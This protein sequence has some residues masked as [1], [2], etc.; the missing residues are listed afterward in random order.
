MKRKSRNHATASML[1]RRAAG[2]S[3]DANAPF[4]VTFRVIEVLL[5]AQ[6]DFFSRVVD[7][8]KAVE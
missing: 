8:N 5:L 3:N 2:A 7:A 1:A 6:G 4:A